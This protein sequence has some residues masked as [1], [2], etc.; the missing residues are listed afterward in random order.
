MNLKR[1]LFLKLKEAKGK[2]RSAKNSKLKFELKKNGSATTL[3]F[4]YVSAHR[5]GL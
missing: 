1:Q 2:K 3:F 4:A 5:Q